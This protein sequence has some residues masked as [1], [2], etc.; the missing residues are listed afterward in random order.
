MKLEELYPAFGKIAIHWSFV[1]YFLDGCVDII[2]HKCGIPSKRINPRSKLTN[3]L[4]FLRE[5]LK[6]PVLLHY[7][8]DGLTI[9]DRIETLFPDRHNIIHGTI[10]DVSELSPHLVNLIKF[11]HDKQT[12]DY[13]LYTNGDLELLGN[14]MMDL[15]YDL[16]RF[17]QR[18][19]N[20]F[21]N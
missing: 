15:A 11:N 13:P 21:G 19:S 18:L 4:V 5:A 2:N 14:E 16:T 8:K 1:E 20:E 3:K 9:A 10:K 7:M 12:Y 17:Y 6:Q